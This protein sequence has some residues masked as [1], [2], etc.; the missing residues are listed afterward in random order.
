MTMITALLA[1]LLF[2]LGLI[3]SGMTDPAKVISFLDVFGGQWNP[4]LAFVMIGAISVSA[5]GFTI[6][7]KQ[8][9]T[10]FDKPITLPDATNIDARLLI[11]AGLFGIGWG[12]A[13]FCPG[14]AL[15]SLTTIA[16]IA[17]PF[18]AAMA[19]GSWLVDRFF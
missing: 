4:A 15:V 5:I 11:G 19:L 1:G 9:K 8:P 16:Q 14:P 12:I 17:V 2:G 18:V 13:G 6:A 3:L 10:V 7:K